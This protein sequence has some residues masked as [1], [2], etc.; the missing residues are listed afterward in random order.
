MSDPEGR[1]RGRRMGRVARWV[2]GCCVGLLWLPGALD[3]TRRQ[4]L[5]M[6]QGAANA[7][8]PRTAGVMR[9]AAQVSQLNAAW[10][11]VGP[12]QVAS[13]RYGLVSGRVTSVAV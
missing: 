7:V 13:Q 4:H 9:G 12:A 8:G 3:A 6:V 2:A 11:A 5:A 1:S 10:T